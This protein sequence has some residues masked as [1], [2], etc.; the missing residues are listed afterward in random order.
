MQLAYF[1]RRVYCFLLILHE[2][3]DRVL[4]LKVAI[5]FYFPSSGEYTMNV[6]KPIPTT[7]MT[8]DDVPEFTEK[9]RN[10]MIDTFIEMSDL[11]Q[12]TCPK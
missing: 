6:L 11:K 4:K 1:L 8:L 3:T 9:V 2:L 7:D 10:T 5:F 12:T